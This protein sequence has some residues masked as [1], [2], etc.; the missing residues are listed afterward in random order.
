MSRSLCEK[1]QFKKTE[2]FLYKKQKEDGEKPLFYDSTKQ[3][4]WIEIKLYKI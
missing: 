4:Y 2:T 3:K 1:V